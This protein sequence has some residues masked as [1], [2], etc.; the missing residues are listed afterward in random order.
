M[1]S[2]LKWDSSQC[3]PCSQLLIVEFSQIAPN[4]AA[5]LISFQ[6]REIKEQAAIKQHFDVQNQSTALLTKYHSLFN[7]V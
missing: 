5:A 3:F 7:K 2:Y 1:S 6:H 4:N